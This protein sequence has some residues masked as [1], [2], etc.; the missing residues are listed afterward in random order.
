MADLMQKGE[1]PI[2]AAAA[3][4]ESS[5]L[6]DT[7]EQEYNISLFPTDLAEMQEMGFQLLPQDGLAHISGA[8]Q[9]IPGLLH[10]R[11]LQN[12]YQETY[13]EAYR[14]LIPE[15]CSIDSRMKIPKLEKEN[16]ESTIFTQNGKIKRHG[17]VQKID[18]P[19]VR[20]QQLAYLAFSAAS[21]A[22][23]QYF[24]YR[25]DKKLEVIGGIVSDILQFLEL[26]KQTKL[27]GDW[28]YL[29]DRYARLQSI[30]DDDRLLQATLSQIQT[31]LTDS[32]GAIQFYQKKVQKELASIKELTEKKVGQASR[33]IDQAR[34]SLSG[35]WLALF[36]H[37]FAV[38]LE[39][40][41]T[42]NATSQ[43]MQRFAERFSIQISEYAQV[44]QFYKALIPTYGEKKAE[45]WLKP[46][47]TAG[48]LSTLLPGIGLVGGG[49]TEV[50]RR[51]SNDII[52]DSVKK[53]EASYALSDQIQPG[54]LTQIAHS[55]GELD[56]LYHGPIELAVS[57][58][59]LYF[60]PISQADAATEDE[61]KG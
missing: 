45:A 57:G 46:T 60:R 31:I 11:N 37:E 55:I 23:S 39:L 35:C 1:E 17:G 14:L 6:L 34:T 32:F 20:A 25:I 5:Q 40:L 30:L 16:A 58:D 29:S 54:H 2:P 28:L 21:V 38:V 24:L 8:L 33:K 22:T 51:H 27:E 13:A 42:Q 61:Q 56:R 52:S 19:D 9:Q 36:V 12:A 49:A 41:L 44:Y 59:Q 50:L 26:D 4:D 53:A 3:P 18:P 15:G 10:G 47:L 7:L 48:T 43:D